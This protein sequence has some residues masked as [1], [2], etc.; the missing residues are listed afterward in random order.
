MLT[1]YI[2][3]SASKG[4]R[5]ESEG[6]VR[7]VGRR[8]AD[9]YPSEPESGS[10]AEES[11][12]EDK[13]EGEQPLMKETEEKDHPKEEASSTAEKKF[14]TEALAADY[15]QTGQKEKAALLQDHGRAMMMT[16]LDD[17]GI[18]ALAVGDGEG[19]AA[20]VAS[21]GGKDLGDKDGTGI[22][23]LAVGGDGEG[24]DAS[25]ASDVSETEL[26]LAGFIVSKNRKTHIV[27]FKPW[28]VWG[29]G[30]PVRR[31]F[32]SVRV[33]NGLDSPGCP[34]ETLCPM[35]VKVGTFYPRSFYLSLKGLSR[36]AKCEK[37]S[38]LYE[39]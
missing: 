11:R 27:R 14:Y 5:C 1:S 28:L 39:H 13:P 4:K 8:V 33:M 7:N 22:V 34:I 30:D 9:D 31:S 23:A 10:D 37:Q 35:K 25:V 24:D 20:S 32:G 29:V 17:K 3:M 26:D 36:C 2:I 18:V 16:D 12:K 38:E 19:D 6:A 15:K 21:D